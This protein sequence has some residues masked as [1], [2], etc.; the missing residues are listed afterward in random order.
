MDVDWV[1]GVTEKKQTLR[2]DRGQCSSVP[3]RWIQV[4]ASWELKSQ[5]KNNKDNRNEQMGLTLGERRA[6]GLSRLI[7]DLLYLGHFLDRQT[8]KKEEKAG[9]EMLT[10]LVLIFKMLGLDVNSRDNKVPSQSV[11]YQPVCLHLN[12]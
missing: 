12:C 2:T 4:W 8:N 3:V 9:R 7:L 11:F 10:L 5:C 1:R 6:E